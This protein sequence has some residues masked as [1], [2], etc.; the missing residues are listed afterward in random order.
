LPRALVW[1]QILF[2]TKVAAISGD[3]AAQEAFMNATKI[4]AIQVGQATL[5]QGAGSV[6][7]LSNVTMKMLA[8]ML[9]QRV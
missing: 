9:I 7:N 4:P 3:A 5:T 6:N 2:W 8:S 1:R